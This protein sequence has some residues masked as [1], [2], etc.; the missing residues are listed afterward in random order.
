MSFA[1]PNGSGVIYQSGRDYN[2]SDLANNTGVTTTTDN[3]I[4]YYDFGTN[5]LHIQGTVWHDPDKEVMLFHHNSTSPTTTTHVFKV[6]ETSASRSWHNI[7][8]WSVDSDGNYVIN[9]TGHSVEAGDALRFRAV[10]SSAI[11]QKQARVLSVTTDTITLERGYYWA[12]LDSDNSFTIT[13]ANGQYTRIPIY[14]YGK[15]YTNYGRTGYS[16]GTGVII[17]GSSTSAYDPDEHGFAFA[18]FSFLWSRG[19]TIINN[20]PCT[21]EGH[22]DIKNTTFMCPRQD[23]SGNWVPVEMR[24]MGDGWWDGGKL[25]NI[26]GV[27]PKNTKQ[28]DVVLENACVSEVL[29]GWYEFSFRNFD[30][31]KNFGV[32]DFGH[33]GSYGKNG[34][35]S[36]GTWSG[37]TVTHHHH[38]FE[39]VNSASGSNVV[40]MWRP[41]QRNPNAQRGNVAT[42][43]EVSFNIKDSSSNPIQDVKLYLADTPSDYAKNATY[44]PATSSGSYTKTPTLLNGVINSDGSITYDYTSPLE[45][46]ATSD[47]NGHISTLKIT[48]SLHIHEY[49]ANDPEAQND[50][51]NLYVRPN[52]YWGFSSTNNR[53]PNFSDWDTDNYGGFYRVDRRSDDNTDA[54]EFTFKFCS[55]GYLLASSTQPLKGLGELQVDWTMFVDRKITET[56]T[57]TVGD[58]TEIDTAARLYDRAK[59]HLYTN[60]VG[61]TDT[62]VDR[63]DL[64]IDAGASN[65]VLIPTTAQGDVFA[66]DKPNDTITIK[67]DSFTGNLK[68]TGTVTIGTNITILGTVTD[69]NNPSGA[70]TRT[71]TIL[72][73]IAGATVQI[74]NE[75]RTTNYQTMIASGTTTN[76]TLIGDGT[77]NLSTLASNASLTLDGV[78]D[79]TFVLPAGWSLTTTTV[80][81]D[82]SRVTINGL[83]DEGDGT[84]TTKDFDLGEI[85]RIRI[86]CAAAAGAFEPFLGTTLTNASGFSLKANQ[87]ADTIY[88]TNGI[89][90]SSAAIE[91][92]FDPDYTHFQIDTTET[93]GV[94]TV[95][96]VYAYYAYLITTTQG[97]DKFFG[98]ITPIDGMNYRINTSVVNLKLQNTT[99]HDTI[100]KGG[101]I[102][103][104]DNTSVIDTDSGTGA[105]TGSFTHDTGFLL[106]YIAP[107]VEAAL[108]NQVASAS[109]MSTVK[110]DVE[111]IK[112]NTGMIPG[113]L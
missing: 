80:V 46:N 43:K 42:K 110:N 57:T 41:V 109:D 58:Y 2:L 34:T 71:F 47:S 96:E 85:V 56:N 50:Y 82:T 62:I 93:D 74:Y 33:D 16:D 73:V 61:E 45:Y 15:E 63:D 77:S 76:S 66:Y 6:A 88:N 14:N 99:Q 52:G 60:F 94:V 78:A 25:I 54:D 18:Q 67:C 68:T 20:R 101:R 24:N 32:C 21:I 31:S 113:L 10:T 40:T 89:D 4:T 100:L 70:S 49:N 53:A 65:I 55:Y 9:H 112:S 87:V 91:A 27:D 29:A 97:I 36:N 51:P 23:S 59:L 11:E 13:T 48:T 38:D 8:S 83:Y 72:N 19:G 1:N 108:S 75:S 86:T 7:S 35:L 44:P 106:Q 30:A 69:T 103:R 92:D 95:Q 37:T 79:G 105:G 26:N 12:G 98:A 3:G 102:Y 5:R 111:S 39:I 81:D 64:T 22:Y 90:G 28:T 104:D 107:Q 84:G 17:S